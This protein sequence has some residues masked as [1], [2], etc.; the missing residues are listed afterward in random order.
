MG[1]TSATASNGVASFGGLYISEPGTYTLTASTTTAP[2]AGL[3]AG[4]SSPATTVADGA[5]TDTTPVQSYSVTL[6]NSLGSSPVT[7]TTFTDADPH[8]AASDYTVS[9][10]WGGSATSTSDSV[11]F[12][13]STSTSSTWKVVGNATYAAAGTYTVSVTVTDVDLA[14]N[15]FTDNHTTVNV[16]G[17][18]TGT[19]SFVQKD[20][21]TKGNWIGPYGNQGY[22]IEGFAADLP[23]YATVGISGASTYVWASSTTDAR[24]LEDPPSGSGRSAQTW[25]GTNFTFD[26]NLT[27]GQEHDVA[28]YA[29]D[30]P[31]IGRQEEF[32]VIDAGTGTVLDTE[33][34]SSFSGGAYLQWEVSGHV[35]IKVTVL[36]G[37]NAV[38]SGLFLDPPAGS[39]GTGTAS[40]VQKDTTT[41]GNWIG[42]Y[43]NQGYD[44][45]GFAAGLPS[46]ATVGISGASTYVWAS[47]TT[48]ARALE[49]PP[50]G[51]G[52]SAQTWFGTNFTFDIN[53]TDGQ[54]HDVA[55]YA[56][57]WP[58]IGRQ[59]EF[60]VIDAGTGTVLDTET[61]SSFSGGAYL[62][63]EV[64]G[65]VQIK[66]TVLAGAN[67]V[68]SGLFL[69]PPAGSTGT[70]TA[71]FVQKDTTTKGNWIGPYGN[72]GYDIEGFA[73]GLPSYATVGISG[74][75]TYVWASSTTD[76][77]ALED[78]PSG[79]G[80]SAQTWFGTNFTFDINLTDGQEH[81]V[82]LYAVDWPNIGRQEEFQVI[83]AGTGTVL[84]TE[85]LSSFSGGAYL[86][87]EVSGHVQ[88][89]V[90]VLAGA[91]AVVSGLFLDP[92][93]TGTT[94]T[95][96]AMTRATA[97]SSGESTTLGASDLPASAI[98]ALDFSRPA[99]TIDA[100]ASL[101]SSAIG[102]LD[103]RGDGSSP[104]AGGSPSTPGGVVRI[105]WRR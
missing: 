65:H 88:I 82:A 8:A 68:V 95:A 91:N 90:T 103:F 94:S 4:T 72:Q 52:R 41:K 38:V 105:R 6:G 29:V 25:F 45:E 102:A 35:Q 19:A 80:R 66:V 18:S 9:V 67:A 36:A 40:F 10:N 93:S 34:L 23:S 50:S 3:T 89:K 59:E 37:A 92:P 49:D 57:D 86:Q 55:L 27:D 31:N 20:T 7:L 53:L 99:S 77:R 101:S 96:L 51:S 48:D 85:T 26:I 44:I 33:T 12:V 98:A 28:L 54:E 104:D 64:S 75:S 56:V 30:W 47:S 16:T 60:Q 62:Q 71:S 46:Y 13:S 100:V 74:A 24:A 42:P 63:W 97:A 78:P 15:T 73:A 39:T 87:W 11:Q 69:D 14:T 83:D 32:Q 43:G 2:W 84:D 70:G 76:A 5:L 22:D 79:S 1:T 21:A 61:L 17:G 58:N 81:D